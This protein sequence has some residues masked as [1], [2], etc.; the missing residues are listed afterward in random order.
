MYKNKL[1]IK[2]KKI[3]EKL[4]ELKVIKETELLQEISVHC[5]P[6][7]MNFNFTITVGSSPIKNKMK[8]KGSKKEHNPPHAHIYIGDNFESRFIIT[9][10]K[11]PQKLE[12]LK[13]VDPKKDDSLK[14]IADDLIVWINSEPIRA[15]SKGNKTNWDAMRS[16]WID[17]QDFV[18]QGLKNKIILHE[19]NYK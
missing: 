11:P 19:P 15:A 1:E 17:I 3:K 13:V 12:D 2:V 5:K 18:N 10:E 16:A 9:D 7:D 8:S 6:G 14:N 4:R